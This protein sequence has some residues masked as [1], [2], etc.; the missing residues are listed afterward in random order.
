MTLLKN[1]A[2][3]LSM[4]YIICIMICVIDF[5]LHNMYNDFC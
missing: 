5:V 4:F 1:G 2:M 3:P